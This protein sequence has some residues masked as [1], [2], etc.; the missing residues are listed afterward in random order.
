MAKAVGGTNGYQQ[1]L[2]QQLLLHAQGMIL[3]ADLV[4]SVSQLQWAF[5]A[6]CTEI[7]E[8][9][10]LVF[11]LLMM[12]L[13]LPLTNPKKCLQSA[14]CHC[15]VCKCFWETTIR[16]FCSNSSS[17]LISSTSNAM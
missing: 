4:L 13:P 15:S 1:M 3:L 11:L 8:V 12:P 16:E 9:T 2:M 7:G 6:D 17:F 14:D 5:R 10:T